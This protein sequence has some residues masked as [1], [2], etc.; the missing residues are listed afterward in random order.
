MY[1][2]FSQF[3]T[4]KT[5]RA[6]TVV[7]EAADGSTVRLPDPAALVTEWRLDY[8]D[9]SDDEASVLIWFFEAREGS[10]NG[11]TF[12]DPVGNL[13]AVSSQLDADAWQRDP[14]LHLTSEIADP[15]GGTRAWQV[16]NS[17]GGP[18][19]IAQTIEATG[20]VTYC[21]SVYARAAAPATAR[22]SIG[23]DVADEL[24][25]AAWT[26]LVFVAT[27]DIEADSVRFGIEVAGGG[28]IEVYGP[29][30]EAQG[31]ASVYRATGRGGV[32]TDA[33]FRGDVFSMTR[34]GCNRNSCTVNIIHA[35]HL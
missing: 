11:F 35:N 13:L 26:R 32:Y 18:Q 4:R 2:H 25:T 30:A 5:R 15:V 28:N 31:G 17:G 22:V 16:S 1:P 34:T 33:H 9:L 21:F 24:V 10:L 6:R 27:P 14:F 20:G 29:Q 8:Q 12:V 23:S 19:T 7:N 3:P